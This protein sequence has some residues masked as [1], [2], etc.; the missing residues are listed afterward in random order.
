MIDQSHNVTDP[1]E[2]LIRSANEIRR[3]YAQALLVDRAALRGYQDENDALMASETLKAGFRLDV[4]PILARARLDAGGAIDPVA[5]FRASG[6]R[7]RVA[8]ERP[9]ARASGGASSDAGGGR[10][11]NLYRT[12]IE[13]LARVADAID[14]AAVDEACRRIAQARHVSVYAGGREGLQVKASPCAC[15]IS[16]VRFRWWAT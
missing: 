12:A 9:A 6:Y 7:A 16:A 15:S 4:E 11:T 1:I 13:E 10:M 5:A 3:A 14:D 8:N 2:S